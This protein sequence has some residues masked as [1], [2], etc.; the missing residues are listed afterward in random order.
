M[1]GSGPLGLLAVHLAA[2]EGADVTVVDPAAG[3]ARDRPAPRAVAAVATAGEL[4]PGASLVFDAAGF[5]PTWRAAIDAVRSGGTVVMLGLGQ[6]EGAFPMA[7]L[8]RRGITLR[9]QFAYSALRFR[10]CGRGARRRRPR[11]RLALDGGARRRCAGVRRP[12]RP[13]RRA[14]E[15]AAHAVSAPSYL[16]TGAYGCIGAWAVRELVAAGTAVTTFD[17]STDPRRLRLLLDDA[18]VAAVPHVAGDISDLAALERV[19]DDREITNVIHLAALQVPFCRA[20]PPLGARVNVLGTVNVFEAV[21]RRADRWPPSSTPR[22]S[23]RSTR[24]RST[25]RRR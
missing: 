9:G 19:L 8:V 23:P 7:V 22:R 13:A 25:W 21:K 11:R 17:L 12:R 4:E 1:L 3:P 6:A 2:R 16:V 24:P 15:S 14:H 5:E 20:D 10:P 18:A